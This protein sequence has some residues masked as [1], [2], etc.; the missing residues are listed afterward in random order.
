M[1]APADPSTRRCRH[2]MSDLRSCPATGAPSHERPRPRAALRR[3]RDSASGQL[4]EERASGDRRSLIAGMLQVSWSTG[5]LNAGDDGYSRATIPSRHT[6]V[7]C[8]PAVYDILTESAR[9]DI[10]DASLMGDH[11]TGIWTDDVGDHGRDAES[12]VLGE[13]LMR[14]ARHADYQFRSGR[15]NCD[16]LTPS[17]AANTRYPRQRQ[18]AAARS[19]VH[20]PYATSWQH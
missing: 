7:V 4:R 12:P 1:A 19:W 5:I 15:P 9:D 20:G 2:R 17:P 11:L 18:Q 8:R 14:A 16:S 10:P 3:P 6:D 13:T